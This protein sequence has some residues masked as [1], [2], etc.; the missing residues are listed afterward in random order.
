MIIS[1]TFGLVGCKKGAN[2]SKYKERA[3]QLAAKYS[4]K[5]AELS[6]KLPELASRAKSLPVTIPG[7]DKVNQMLAENQSSLAQA[8]EILA[9]LPAKLG[10]DSPEQAEQDLAKAEKLLESDVAV[11]ERDETMEAEALAK[12]EAEEKTAT[13]A[14]SGT[15]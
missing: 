7:A 3:A 9:G 10:A 12:L 13:G 5:L 2:L 4:P 8:Q 1:L 15:K 14:G 11:A 6:K